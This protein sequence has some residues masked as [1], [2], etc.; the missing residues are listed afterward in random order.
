MRAGPAPPCSFFRAPG[1]TTGPQSRWPP[2]SCGSLSHRSRSA[3]RARAI[4]AQAGRRK[5]AGGA[6][7]PRMNYRNAINQLKYG[8]LN[9]QE[10]FLPSLLLFLLCV[11]ALHNINIHTYIYIYIRIV[12]L[13][14]YRRYVYSDSSSATAR[15]RVTARGASTSQQP[16]RRGGGLWL[17]WRSDLAHSRAP[18]P[19]NFQLVAPSTSII[20]RCCSLV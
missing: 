6:L 12:C 4:Q 18:A 8:G 19:G 17:S 14:P 1:A 5:R 13:Y 16:P 11:R 20:K 7:R 15:A 3:V 10:S 9:D 2:A